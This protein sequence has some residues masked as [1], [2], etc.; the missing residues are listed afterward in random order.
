MTMSG[1]MAVMNTGRIVQ[2]GTPSEIYEFPV[3]RFVADFI[4]TANMFEGRVTHDAHDH[5]RIETPELSTELLIS[6]A[7]PVPLGT[8][9]SVAVRPEKIAIVPRGAAPGG[10]TNSAEGIVRDIAYMGN[11]SIYIVEIE[12]GKRVQVT[13]P[14][15]TRLAERPITWDDAVRIE[16]GP[17]SGVVLLQ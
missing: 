13:V 14:N 6:H 10:G 1:R 9:V 12:S 8:M 7:L 3:S 17:N 15:L 11:L 16:W 5:V 4:G 2:V